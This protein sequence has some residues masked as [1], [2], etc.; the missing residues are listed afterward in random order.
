MQAEQ[1]Y[2]VYNREFLVLIR[3]FKFWRYLLE[4][5]GHQ[6][7]VYT[8]HAN[9]IKHREVQKLSGN[10]ARYITFLARFNFNICHLPGKKNTVAD[11][12]SRQSDRTPPEGEEMKAIP[13]PN[14][15]FIR[16]IRP[17]AVEEEIKRQQKCHHYGASDSSGA[18][19]R[20]G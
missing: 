6:I 2:D 7:K 19:G 8:N 15:L 14:H 9:L 1:N 17:M 3:A 16:L 20:R 4:G 5:S 10:V 18:R 11:A 13:L 12:L